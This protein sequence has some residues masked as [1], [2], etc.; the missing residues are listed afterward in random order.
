MMGE[1]YSRQRVNVAF[2]IG[3]ELRLVALVRACNVYSNSVPRDALHRFINANSFVTTIFSS[4]FPINTL[5]YRVSGYKGVR[6]FFLA[7]SPVP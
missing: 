6:Y 2:R 3:E 1:N 7:L 5:D 4:S